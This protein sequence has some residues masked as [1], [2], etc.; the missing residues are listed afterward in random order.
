ME[1]ENKGCTIFCD[2]K[3]VEYVRLRVNIQCVG[4]RVIGIRKNMY[5][6]GSK[7]QDLELSLYIRVV[8]FFSK[9]GLRGETMRN[10]KGSTQPSSL[11]GRG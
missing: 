2:K 8:G 3:A 10:G 1:K 9:L 5:N 4:L 6:F 7:N 11:E